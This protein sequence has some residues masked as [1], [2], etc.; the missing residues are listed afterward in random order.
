[1]RIGGLAIAVPF[2][3]VARP[4]G[5]LAL[6]AWRDRDTRRHPP[7][8]YREDASRLDPVRVAEV[9]PIA[10]DPPA[11]ERQLAALV[12]RARRER[13]PI[14]I[15]GAR[16]SMGGH[17]VYPDG[18]VLDMTPFRAMS[19]DPSAR[20]LHVQAGARW[21]EVLPF[22]NA[23]GLSVSVMQSNS[24]FT[25]GGTASVNAHGWQL[26]HAPFA[27][28]VESFRLLLADGH[29]VRCSRSENPELFS[30]AL[31]GY[32][33]FGVI[34]DLDLR[35]VPNALYRLE[36]LV[37]QSDGYPAL[38]AAR[39]GDGADVGMAYGRLSI[40]RRGFL[41]ES[42]LALFHRVPTREAVR[43]RLE[44]PE[45]FGFARLVFRGSVGSEYGKELRWDAEKLFGRVLSG[46]QTSRNEL[47]SEPVEVNENRMEDTTDILHEYFV[48]RGSFVPFVGRVREIVPRYR[49][50]LLNITIRD[51]REDK[52]TFLRYADRD[53][54]GLVMLFNQA[55]TGAGERDMEALTRELVDSAVA[56]GGRP[57][58]P[59]RRHATAA[60][61]AAAYPQAS[62]F[63]A[64]KRRYD[65]DEVFQN[66][67][68]AAYGTAARADDPVPPAAVEPNRR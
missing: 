32:G 11:A 38:F 57:Y 66:A 20:L 36:A 26:D 42:I 61:L 9:V 58:L 7:P 41:A 14:A 1:M 18:I 31:G 19:L 35:V 24:S 49:A 4:A 40:A 23:Q 28:T 37:T 62:A 15:A 16:H 59:Y 56:L 64:R 21:S 52:D 27:S 13:R 54:F 17:T 47:L 30:L 63:F 22:L 6:T 48:P 43:S 34:L 29:V 45:L 60:Q 51:V 10:A 33:L 5:H 50:D 65:P 44:Y 3:L 39:T 12:E 55:R 68:Y 8:G 67:F 46:R 53:V 25:V 2:A